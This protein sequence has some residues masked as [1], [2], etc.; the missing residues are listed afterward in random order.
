LEGPTVL[1]FSRIHGDEIN[2]V[3]IAATNYKENKQTQ[4]GTII[5]IPH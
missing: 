1:F 2:G 3:E 5:C 4:E